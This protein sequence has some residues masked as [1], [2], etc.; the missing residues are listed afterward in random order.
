MFPE[1]AKISISIFGITIFSLLI[2]YI[3]LHY[4]DFISLK[5]NLID[6]PDN[7][8]KIHKTEV[9]LIA[10]IPT[11]IIFNILC[12]VYL[13]LFD[14]KILNVIILCNLAYLIGLFDDIKNL[15]YSKKL[16]F[17]SLILLVAFLNDQSLLIDKLYISTFNLFLNL[18]QLESI[19]FT[20]ICIL[21]LINA[22]NLVDGINALAVI[23]I[24]IWSIYIIVFF[25]SRFNFVLLALLPIFIIKIL[26]I[27]KDKYFL[28]D[29]GSFFLGMLI[30]VITIHNYNESIILKKYISC[31][32]LFLL[33]MIPG[34][35]MF[36]LFVQRICNRKHPFK[37]DNE[38]LHHY[39]IRRFSL[40]KSLAFYSILILTPLILGTFFSKNLLFICFF[41]TLY[42]LILFFLKNN[43]KN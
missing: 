9:P 41:L 13:F 42:F 29:S 22:I 23:I 20:I 30:S 7:K 40:L 24:T 8:R 27:Y 17:L 35:D 2:N 26:F 3:V 21:L 25:E 39:L 12:F 19:F 15:S 37:A 11:L 36:R 28:G 4:R 6:Y 16:T 43:R 10:C 33:F 31:E 34:I 14:Y 1:L 5:L 32:N 18:N 38:H